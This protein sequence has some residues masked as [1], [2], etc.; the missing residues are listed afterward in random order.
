MEFWHLVLIFAVFLAGL[1]FSLAYMLRY[2]AR[3]N[4]ELVAARKA[5]IGQALSR[6]RNRLRLPRR[7]PKRGGVAA[8]STPAPPR[9][10]SPLRERGQ[11]APQISQVT[12]FGSNL[13][14]DAET[15][16]EEGHG[17]AADERE[18]E[19]RED[20]DPA[21]GLPGLGVAR[22]GTGDDAENALGHLSALF[23]RLERGDLPIEEFLKAAALE[24]EEAERQIRCLEVLHGNRAALEDDP[25]FREA[26]SHCAAAMKCQ[27]WALEFREN[28]RHAHV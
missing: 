25:D 7:K 18:R 2:W 5:R 28:L 21:P 15:A 26:L 9:F 19:A 13:S 4:R 12:G 3:A 10:R 22:P 27:Q 24:R 1:A 14:R 23:D 20:L 11:S 16:A 17:L 8:A 6:M